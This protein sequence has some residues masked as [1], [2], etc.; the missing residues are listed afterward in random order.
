VRWRVADAVPRGRRDHLIR[1]AIGFPLVPIAGHR[2]L[3][4]RLQPACGG[5]VADRTVLLHRP[6]RRN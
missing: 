4:L 5:L 1:D 2:D 6:S 3:M